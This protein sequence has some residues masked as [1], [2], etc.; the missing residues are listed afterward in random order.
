M[1]VKGRSVG[2]V[3]GQ[4]ARY[5]WRMRL[6][7]SE[8][9]ICTR[10]GFDSRRWERRDASAV[11]HLLGNWWRRAIAD[12]SVE[13]LNRRPAPGVW[14]A[15]EYGLHS[16]MVVPILRHAIEAML[17]VDRVEV[18]DPCPGVDIEDNTRPLTLD[19]SALLDDLEREGAALGWLVD[20]H[21]EGWGHLGRMEDGTWWQA[22]ATFL[23]AVHDTTHHFLDVGEGLARVG[24]A[25]PTTEATVVS[26]NVSD[27]EGEIEVD[28]QSDRKHHGRPFQAVCLWSSE[29]IEQPAGEGQAIGAGTVGEN[30]TL[31]GVD[32]AG[33]R[34]GTRLL[35]GTALLELSYPA[36]PCPEQA[37]W[38]CDG[39][40]TRLSHAEHPEW[41]R[42]YAWVRR[43]GRA[44][45]GDPAVV[46]P[47]APA[48]GQAIRVA[49][50]SQ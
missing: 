2:A 15:L 8:P 44:R 39:D 22:E 11:F 50:P 29:A 33:L 27:E 5:R 42:W 12:M 49:W 23:H 1:A 21:R 45:P 32:W 34:P 25:A 9:E 40:I 46:S 13:D 18:H 17:A 31:S 20:N 10:C 36:T 38:F 6:D 7:G 3:S 30:L 24:A 4:A 14:S 43:P 16:A 47:A 37:R 19:P 26:V 35:A 48:G 41:A 28:R